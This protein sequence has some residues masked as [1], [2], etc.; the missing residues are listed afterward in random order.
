A[1]AKGII[2]TLS[3]LGRKPEE[4]VEYSYKVIER[5][6]QLTVNSLR[7]ILSS[8]GIDVRTIE[9][10][11]SLV[12]V[13]T[14]KQ[15][16]EASKI[17]AS[18]D[19]EE[20]TETTIESEYIV[21]DTPEG[22]GPQELESVL[23][24]LGIPTRVLQVGNFMILT[25]DAT[26]LADSE[27]LIR[28]IKMSEASSTATVT[29]SM[30]NYRVMA[31]PENISFEEM[32]RTA[33]SLEMTLKFEKIGDN[34][35]VI[36]KDSEINFFDRVITDI[37][38]VKETSNKSVMF[39]KR[40][41]GISAT[42]LSGYLSTRGVEVSV[43][44]VTDGYLLSGSEEELRKAQDFIGY[45]LSEREKGYRK[46]KKTTLDSEKLMSVLTELAIDV[47]LLE[48][49]DSLLLIGKEE[50]LEKA[51]KVIEDLS[52]IPTESATVSVEK[53]SMIK[54]W[55]I[56]RIRQY[57]KF[58]GIEVEN[59]FEVDDSL[60]V[61]GTPGIIERTKELLSLVTGDQGYYLKLEDRS[62][63]GTQLEE[64]ISTMSLNVKYIALED[65]WL[66]VG[67][68]VD[69]EKVRDVLVNAKKQEYVKYIKG[70]TTDATELISLLEEAFPQ[71]DVSV[72]PNL[73]MILIK[74]FDEMSLN[75]AEA[76][77]KDILNGKRTESLEENI[78]LHNGMIDIDVEKADLRAVLKE[79]AKDLGVSL[80]MDENISDTITISAKGLKWEDFVSILEHK[81]YTVTTTGSIYAISGKGVKLETPTDSA[82]EEQ[83]YRIYH[84]VEEFKSLIE[85]YGG[86]VYTDPINGIVVVKGI[87]RSRV[88]EI[89]QRL[90]STFSSP[91]KQVKIETKIMDK[92]LYDNVTKQLQASLNLGSSQPQ[93][94]FNKDSIGLSFNVIDVVDFP[95]LLENFITSA[96]ATVTASLSEGNNDS[97]IV[98]NPSIVA[99][100]GEQARIHIGDTIPY[101]IKKVLEDG[102]IVEELNYL[103]TG[104][105]MTITPTING[106]G[107]IMLDLY[108]KVSDPQQYGDYYG[109]KTREA[110][111][112]LMIADGNSLSIG[113]LI[114]EKETVNVTKLPFLGDLPF[115]GKLFT[116]ETKTKEQREMVIIITAKVVEP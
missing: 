52:V 14:R 15:V 51:V 72:F 71:V 39:I 95:K 56:E 57:L 7:E 84:N 25:G 36:G 47:K 60:I 61:I 77:I 80:L 38:K 82:T 30:L 62:V 108:I 106:D 87:E 50:E 23:E 53:L 3:S 63:K 28:N 96:S 107:T 22:V 67:N 45:L 12:L 73:E 94:L 46:I 92:S 65:G 6:V 109:E 40:L 88:L 66:L 44:D 10:G 9:V 70:I 69:V 54:G 37:T 58:A 79:V 43:T 100:S 83:I 34:V 42:D 76:F 1:D 74:S 103:N 35:L 29:T 13:G 98:S 24:V 93:I 26:S 49:D 97:D 31:I 102:T 41:S 110:Q 33:E 85:F 48:F 17:I 115:I 105:E 16:E 19:A 11:N 32:T 78:Q 114:T 68:R 111:T 104:V 91:K 81:G 75:A 86:T 101:T 89:L 5:P 112:K 21:M 55:D 2:A 8:I 116:T 27:R 18:F 20:A 113:G 4:L 59:L 90:E 99:L 64:L